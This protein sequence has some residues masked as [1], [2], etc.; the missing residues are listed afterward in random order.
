M[1]ECSEEGGGSGGEDWTV[2]GVSLVLTFIKVFY[3]IPGLLFSFATPSQSAR[4]HHSLTHSLTF[5][6]LTTTG[7]LL[8]P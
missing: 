6:L 7:H 5:C 3:G 2:W 4:V 1:S 8:L